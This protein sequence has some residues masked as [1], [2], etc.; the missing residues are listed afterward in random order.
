[1]STAAGGCGAS[2]RSMRSIPSTSLAIALRVRLA[3]RGDLRGHGHVEAARHGV[4]GREPGEYLAEPRLDLGGLAVD[5]GGGAAQAAQST[6]PPPLGVRKPMREAH[7]PDT[8]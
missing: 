7:R 6:V 5:A 3:P 1:M 4:F 8:E 2:P